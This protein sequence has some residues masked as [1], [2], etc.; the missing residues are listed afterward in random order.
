[1]VGGRGYSLLVG[2]RLWQLELFSRWLEGEGLSV[3]ELTPERFVEFLAR[4]ACGG[5]RSWTSGEH[6]APLAY[7]REFG[8]VAARVPGVLD[9]P[10]EG[11]LA[12]YRC[13]MYERGVP[14]HRCSL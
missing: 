2:H 6:G 13:W 4:A 9:G 8:V 10:V 12:D 1:M 7:L 3:E 5:Y 14:A 11:V